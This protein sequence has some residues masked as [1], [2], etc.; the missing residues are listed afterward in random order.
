MTPRE[1]VAK[2]VSRSSFGIFSDPI[3]MAMAI[4]GL[5]PRNADVRPVGIVRKD[6]HSTLARAAFDGFNVGVGRFALGVAQT[7]NI[8]ATHTFMFPTAPSIVR[9][10]S[11]QILGHRQIFHLRPEEP[12]VTSSP[13]GMPWA[14]GIISMPL[15]TLAGPALQALGFDSGAALD[16]DRMFLVPDR[17]MERLVGLMADVTRIARDIPQV[18]EAE[19]PAK[20]LGGTILEALLTCLDTGSVRPDRAALRRHRQIVARFEDALREHPEEMLSLSDICAAVGVAARTLNLACQE[21]LGQ[22]AVHYARGYRLDLV[23]Q[24]LLAG[25][26][27]SV[28]VTQIA[29]DYG[30]WELGRFAQAYRSRFD[31]APSQT[32]R[33]DAKRDD[34]R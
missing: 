2:P 18:L 10:V 17:P 14:F 28:Q 31:E 16:D 22:G 26:P 7:A 21:F 12:T 34:R 20:A 13:S 32:L 8:G 27:A 9:R 1:I 29:M 23:R 11:G 25:D 5:D 24:R 6:F 15:G 33:R 19:A 30:F 3:A 4:N